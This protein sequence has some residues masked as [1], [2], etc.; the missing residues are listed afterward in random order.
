MSFLF[1]FLF[2]CSGRVYESV[3]AAGALV[4]VWGCSGLG[5]GSDDFRHVGK[6]RLMERHVSSDLRDRHM[7]VGVTHVGAGTAH[8]GAWENWRAFPL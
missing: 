8:V 3:N 5:N 4:V 2:V 7:E 1:M 6:G